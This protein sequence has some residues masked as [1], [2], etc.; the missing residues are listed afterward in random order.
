MFIWKHKKQFVTDGRL[1]FF[2][3]QFLGKRCFILGNGPSLTL[4]DIERLRWEY[5]FASNKIYLC[6]PQT[7]WRPSFYMV[8]DLLVLE[9]NIDILHNLSG[10]TCFYPHFFQKKLGENHNRIYFRALPA[11]YAASPLRDPEFPGFSYDA[12]QGI[13]WG[14]TVIYSQIQLAVFMGFRELYL[15]GVDHQYILPR[16]KIKNYYISEGEKNHF[17]PDYR[18]PGEKWY[19]PQ[20][21]VMERSYAHALAACHHVG[22]KLGNASRQTCLNILPHVNLDEIVLP[23]ETSVRN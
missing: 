19:Q 6:F 11:Q 22:V 8:E 17:H 20:L 23:P 2:R 18:K 13:F 5:T 10:T 21:E 3:N 9:Q 16:K 7:S 4:E 15:L 14:S 1:L 12:L